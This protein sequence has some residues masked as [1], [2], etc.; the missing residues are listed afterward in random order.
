VR[1]GI[2]GDAATFKPLSGVEKSAYHGVLNPAIVIQLAPHCSLQPRGALWFFASLCTVSF[3]IAGVLAL[4][5]LWP[6]LPFAGLEMVVLGWALTVSLRRRH[7]S[8]TITVTEER[9]L[10]DTRDR[11]LREQVEFPRHWARVK[12]RGAD[13][14]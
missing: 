7:Y 2:P 10:I 6:V 9:V 14:P 1:S 13:T 8:Q 5:G 11:Q 4:R 12:L 3:G